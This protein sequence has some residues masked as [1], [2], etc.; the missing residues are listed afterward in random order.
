MGV[1]LALREPATLKTVFVEWPWSLAVGVAGVLTSI[2][3]F[4]A[5]TME[6][7]AHVRALGQIE[8]VFTFAASVFFFRERT[9]W[10]EV[11]GIFLVGGG[12]LTLVLGR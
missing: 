12:I 7:A 11:L 8:L 6:N 9:N 5:F 4:T 10:V 3:W 1:Y 2:G